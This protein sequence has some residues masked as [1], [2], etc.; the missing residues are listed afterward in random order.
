MKKVHCDKPEWKCDNTQNGT[1][2][3]VHY[4]EYHSEDESTRIAICEGDISDI[5]RLSDKKYCPSTYY[6]WEEIIHILQVKSLKFD[7]Y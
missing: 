7:L 2:D 1:E 4:S 6:E 5:A 3:E